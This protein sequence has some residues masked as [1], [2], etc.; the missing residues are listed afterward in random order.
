MLANIQNKMSYLMVDQIS[1]GLARQ[2]IGA[3]EPSAMWRLT[4]CRMVAQRAAVPTSSVP[5]L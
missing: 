5:I 1:A 4:E 3:D 2:A